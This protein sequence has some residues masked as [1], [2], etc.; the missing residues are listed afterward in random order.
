VFSGDDSIS[1]IN[2]WILERKRN[3]PNSENLAKKQEKKDKL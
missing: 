2:K 3:Y 1:E